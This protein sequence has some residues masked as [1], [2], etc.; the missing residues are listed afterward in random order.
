MAMALTL[1]IDLMS[2]RGK[3]RNHYGSLFLEQDEIQAY[4]IA[5]LDRH[6]HGQLNNVEVADYIDQLSC[7]GFVEVTTEDIIV[8]NKRPAKYYIVLKKD[9]DW[10]IDEIVVLNRFKDHPRLLNLVD[11]LN[12]SRLAHHLLVTK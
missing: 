11:E 12:L 7:T 2:E 1:V 6:E 3:R 5:A 9:H 4:W 10:C 8:N